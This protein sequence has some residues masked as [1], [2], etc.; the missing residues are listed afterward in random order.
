VGKAQD[1]YERLKQH[2]YRGKWKW[3]DIKR[4]FVEEEKSA[5]RRS[6]RELERLMEET[7]GK[8]P[9]DVDDVLNRIKPPK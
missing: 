2:V 5:A 1:I 9:A 4:I 3:E 8:H 7:G 6:Q